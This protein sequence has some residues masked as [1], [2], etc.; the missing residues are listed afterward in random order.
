MTQASQNDIAD[1][2]RSQNEYE[3]SSQYQ[4]KILHDDDDE[5]TL[6]V[7]LIIQPNIFNSGNNY[8][9]ESI[10]KQNEKPYNSQPRLRAQYYM[11]W[12]AT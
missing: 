9:L 11:L 4:Y 1:A 8:L 2:P 6:C 3:G 5:A 7:L 10:W 12:A